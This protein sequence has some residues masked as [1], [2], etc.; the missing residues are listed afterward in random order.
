MRQRYF[1]LHG[2][3]VIE[4]LHKVLSRQ[5]LLRTDSVRGS[6]ISV[7]TSFIGMPT[8]FR[9]NKPEC[10]ESMIFGGELNGEFTRYCDYD[11]A[12]TGHQELVEAVIQAHT[13]A[14]LKIINT[15]R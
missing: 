14:S 5:P 4:T 15:T 13:K 11:E 9:G 2:K 10:F 12:I 6:G 8:F 7:Y 1:K 3:Q